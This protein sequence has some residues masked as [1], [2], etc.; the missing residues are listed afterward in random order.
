MRREETVPCR[1]FEL[2]DLEP[3][4]LEAFASIGEAWH[5]Q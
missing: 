4:L 5:S 2:H 1:A 3:L